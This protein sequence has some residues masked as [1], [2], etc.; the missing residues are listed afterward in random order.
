MTRVNDTQ[1]RA[2][3]RSVMTRHR[4]D[5][6][7]TSFV[8]ARGI[9]RMMGELRRQQEHSAHPIHHTDVEALELDMSKV[10]GVVRI[11]MDLKEWQ[12]DG[13]G[14][15]SDRARPT[16]TPSIITPTPA[17]PGDAALDG[18]GGGP[19]ILG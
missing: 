15:W 3:L 16:R 9:V 7:K 18:E 8:C 11:H 12:R 10:R 17:E 19:E 1:V 13:S 14:Q 4:M 2:E 6:N 5:L